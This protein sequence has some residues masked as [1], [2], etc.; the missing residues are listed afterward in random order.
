MKPDETLLPLVIYR[1]DCMLTPRGAG[2]LEPIVYLRCSIL[3]VQ[4]VLGHVQ[5]HHTLYWALS[6]SAHVEKAPG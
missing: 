2:V 4:T 5:C 6:V 3:A 1:P